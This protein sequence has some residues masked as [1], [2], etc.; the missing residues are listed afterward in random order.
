MARTD[1]HCDGFR[2]NQR[3]ISSGLPGATIRPDETSCGSVLGAGG[4]LLW[5]EIAHHLAEPNGMASA[6]VPKCSVLDRSLLSSC[7]RNTCWDPTR[8]RACSWAIWS[9]SI[10]PADIP[11][12]SNSLESMSK[13]SHFVENVPK[14]TFYGRRWQVWTDTINGSMY[15]A[16]IHEHQMFAHTHF[17]SDV[18]DNY[19]R[20]MSDWFAQYDVSVCI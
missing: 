16:L 1:C 9:A 14:H 12:S 2:C 17:T 18:L 10:S 20:I 7:C 19:A 15:T 11:N 3:G 8:A 4:D 5:I 6:H 13:M